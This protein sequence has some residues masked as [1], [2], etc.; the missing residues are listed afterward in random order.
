MSQMTRK[1]LALAAAAVF[2][3][4]TPLAL[5]PTAPL[6]VAQNTQGVDINART[7]LTIDKRLGELDS[8]TPLE[9]SSFLIER[10]QMTNP[11]NTA[12][13]WR[14]A[15]DIV[16]AGA[17]AA[18]VTGESQTQKTSSEG[19][20]KFSNLAVGMYRVTE[21]Q[22]GNY[23]VAAPFLVT[24]P[25]I[26][27]GVVNYDP[28][29][30]PKNQLLLPTKAADDTN[31]TVGGD[32]VY[33]IKAP[34]PAGDVLQDGTRTIN[35]F[36]IVDQLQTGLTYNQSEP[37]R[38]TVTGGPAGAAFES[39]DDGDY[40]VAWD[41][42]SNTLT[43][44]FTEAGRT[45]LAD[46]RASNP[47]LTV[48]VAFNATVNQIPA[49]GRFEN[50]AQVF[51]P[52]A[53]KPIDTTPETDDDGTDDAVTTQYVDVA[54]SK[55]VNGENVDEDATGAGAKFEIYACTANG[56][57][58]TVADNAAPLAGTNAEGT[59][60]AGTTITTAGGSVDTAAVAN[61]YALQFD[62]GK[63]Y[64]AVETQ[65]PSGYLLNP[66]PTPLDSTGETADGRPIY[67]A[68][69]NN[70]RD[71]IFGRLPATG[72]RTMIA[73]LAIG[74]VLFAGGAAY[75]LRRNNA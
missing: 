15:S 29:I 2:A 56:D 31:V 11:L 25:L 44:N 63:Q 41:T 68:T 67:T 51:I 45:K 33:T 16:A 66:D 74:L 65:A 75:Q 53:E 48:N 19:Q 24:L 52:N 1:T 18:E 26:E 32:I 69:V 13:G 50:T 21:V 14:E 71:N 37:A 7:S 9:G 40:T 61:G 59:A 47:G 73:L 35:Q 20:A 4:A 58:Y 6:A 49:N 36:R 38:V 42:A 54:V 17:E 43:V 57:S 3:T 46:W 34:V 27:D 62:P 64:C 70:V 5:G 12:A 23:T 28:T 30:S 72:E 55:T 22:N 8:T 60:T 39:G 10:V